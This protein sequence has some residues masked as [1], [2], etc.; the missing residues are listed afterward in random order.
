MAVQ[1][2]RA[3]AQ[4]NPPQ[5]E[6]YK[7]GETYILDITAKATGFS[8]LTGNVIYTIGKSQIGNMESSQLN[9]VLQQMTVGD[10]YQFNV[11]ATLDSH[12]AVNWIV[13]GRAYAKKDQSV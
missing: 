11:T 1:Q 4:V 13:N 9:K 2:N 6:L 10:T 3:I 12:Y 5:S 7:K 8:S